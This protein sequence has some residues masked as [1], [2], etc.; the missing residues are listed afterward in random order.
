MWK[1][2]TPNTRITLPSGMCAARGPGSNTTNSPLAMHSGSDRTVQFLRVSLRWRGLWKGNKVLCLVLFAISHTVVLVVSR[3][4]S[5]DTMRATSELIQRLWVLNLWANTQ[6]SYIRE[7]L[8]GES[9]GV[10]RLTLYTHLHPNIN[11]VKHRNGQ[12]APQTRHVTSHHSINNR[13]F[14]V[15]VF[16]GN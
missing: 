2:L 15:N 14:R 6:R 12:Y 4:E 7:D 11:T 5:R 9:S 10:P 8:W 13:V 16:F 3:L 1:N